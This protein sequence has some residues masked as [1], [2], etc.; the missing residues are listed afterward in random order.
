MQILTPSGFKS[1]DGVKRYW[2]D[3]GILF[4]FSDGSELKTSQLHRF[5]IN[6]VEVYSKDVSVGDNIGKIVVDKQ[7]INDGDYYYDPINVDGGSIFVHDDK[8][9][10]HN[11]F[12]GSGNTLISGDKLLKLQAESPLYEQ[13][14]VRVYERPNP[15]AKYMMF[16][17]VAKGRGQDYSTFNVIDISVKPFRQVAV[18]RDNMISPLLFPDI[19]HK[20][21]RTYNDAYVVIENNDQGAVVCNGLYYEIEYENVFVESSIKSDGI[22]VLMT[23][24]IKRIGTSNMKDLIEQDKLVIRDADTIIELS[25]F[26]AKG[27][28]YEASPG[29]H[30]DLVMNLV[31]FGWFT[32]TP[33][34]VEE[35]DLDIRQMLYAEQM[36]M[37]ED[38]LVPFGVIDDGLEEDIEIIQGDRWTT[39]REDPNFGTFR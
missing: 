4:T 25:T 30:D 6:G 18:F 23:R 24:K 8:I 2:H 17:D 33:M 12:L 26:V 1:F 22:G 11:T 19:I 13:D 34:F 3:T 28:S 5:V 31:L 36:K 7:S 14:G 35:T 15:D 38:D 20:Y 16:V 27:S 21:A 29:N 9:I 10:S 39:I 32:T 37:I